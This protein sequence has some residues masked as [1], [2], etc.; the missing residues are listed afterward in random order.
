MTRRSPVRGA[1][2][3]AAALAL[4]SGCGDPVSPVQSVYV[5][6]E[7]VPSPF[8]GGPLAAPPRAVNFRFVGQQSGIEASLTGSTLF[9]QAV[10][11]D[12][13]SVVVIAP[14]GQV[15]NGAVVRVSVPSSGTASTADAVRLLQAAA[16]DYS[17]ISAA[18]YTMKIQALQPQ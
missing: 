13:V 10:A 4:A 16:A 3:L 15:L 1:V 6:I 2:V 12:T 11:G 7:T 18:S 9:T 17:L 8:G 14:V 5:T